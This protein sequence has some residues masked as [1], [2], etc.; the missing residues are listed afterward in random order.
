MQ[1]SLLARLMRCL[2]AMNL[3]YFADGRLHSTPLSNGLADEN[4]QK[5]IRFCY[6]VTRPAFNCFPEY[7][8]AHNYQDVVTAIDGPFQHAMCPDVDMPMHFFPWL[9][10]NPPNLDLFAAFMSAYRAGHKNWWDPGFYPV[11]ERL[12]EGFDA[13]ASDVLLVDMGGGRGHDLDQLVSVHQNRP[14]RVILQDQE[15]VIESIEKK[16]EKA[17]EATLHDFFT[18]QVVKSAR[19][20]SLHSILH[21]WDDNDS[22]QIL[23][24]LRPALKPG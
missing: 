4:F 20:Y 10:Y 8:K 19:A 17:Y 1:A 21:D 18:P 7:F 5:T 6:E 15:A 11:Q 14:G 23:E 16:A 12:V 24:N 13:S 9:Q 3:L 22:L 2:A